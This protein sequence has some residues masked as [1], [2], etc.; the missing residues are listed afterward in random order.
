[1]SLSYF[2]GVFKL[3]RDHFFDVI[4]EKIKK[5]MCKFPCKVMEKQFTW[6]YKGG[7]LGA[8]S[9]DVKK[10]DLCKFLT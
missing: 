8:L 6:D 9:R 7:P 5:K 4:T 3:A 1:M 10:N 2:R